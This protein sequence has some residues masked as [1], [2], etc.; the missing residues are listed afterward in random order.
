MFVQFTL[1][2]FLLRLCSYKALEGKYILHIKNMN[3][4]VL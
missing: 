4:N 1:K 2:I 3:S